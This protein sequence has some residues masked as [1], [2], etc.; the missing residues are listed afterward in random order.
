MASSSSVRPIIGRILQQSQRSPST[1]LALAP[2]SSPGTSNAPFSTTACLE[3]RKPKRDNNR[4]RG[5]SSIYR[6]GTK[7]RMTVDG[8]ELPQPAKYNPADEVKTDP[9]HGLYEFFYDKEKSLLSP[10]EEAQHGRSWTV[11]ELRHKSWEDLHKLWW[12]SVKERNRNAT[13]SRERKRLK[14]KTGVEEGQDRMRT[15]CAG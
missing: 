4:L 7:A 3:M 1:C 6:S 12:T 10:E 14:F 8:F 13:A 11:E 9:N 2:R 5:L 15:V